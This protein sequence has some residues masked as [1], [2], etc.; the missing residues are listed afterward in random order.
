MG[1]VAD[2]IQLQ[3]LIASI[4]GGSHEPAPE[5]VAVADG[6]GPQACDQVV[7]TH[8]HFRD[9]RRLDVPVDENA[10][11][12]SGRVADCPLFEGRRI[13]VLEDS[14]NPRQWQT[15][16]AFANLKPSLDVTRVLN[17][18]Q[19]DAWLSRLAGSKAP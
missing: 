3:T 1:G 15:E 17:K 4:R 14:A 19:V 18:E 7:V 9:F 12:D 16:R 10:P 2:N 5:V 13:V 11:L 8:W 6:S